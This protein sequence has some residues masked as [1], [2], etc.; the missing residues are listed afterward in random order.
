LI[1]GKRLE[2]QLLAS[3]QGSVLCRIVTLGKCS[4]ATAVDGFG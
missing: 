1:S 4:A 3:V 2:L